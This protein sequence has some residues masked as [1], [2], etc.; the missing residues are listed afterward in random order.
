MNSGAVPPAGERGNRGEICFF[1]GHS[2]VNAQDHF[3]KILLV[4]PDCVTTVFNKCYLFLLR[5]VFY[6]CRKPRNSAV[7]NLNRH[8]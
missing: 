2:T 5:L 1:S 4:P 8:C 3:R 7:D 6:V